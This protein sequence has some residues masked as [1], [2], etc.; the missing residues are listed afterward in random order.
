MY[1]KNIIGQ[2]LLKKHLRQMAD[3]EHIAHALLFLGEEGF[4]SMSLPLAFAQYLNCRERKDGDACGV[5]PSCVKYHSLA[6]PDLH[7]LFPIISRGTKKTCDDYLD[8]WREF[9]SEEKYFDFEDWLQ[10]IEAG[11]SQP[12]IYSA[13]SNILIKK[14]AFKSQEAD[15]RVVLIWM[16]EKMNEVCANKLLKLIEEPPSRTIFLMVSAHADAIL[17]TIL[18]RT[19]Q[20]IVPPIP[21][22]ELKSALIN[23][24]EVEEDEAAVVARIAGA[25]YVT[26]RRLLIDRDMRKANFELFATLMR[27]AWSRNIKGMKQF[28]EHLNKLGREAQKAFLEY[29]QNFIRESYVYNFNM[30]QINYLTRREEEFATNFARFIHARNVEE[31]VEELALAQLH[32]ERNVNSKMIFFDLS[33]RMTASIRKEI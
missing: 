15:W 3:Q 28:A 27:N 13:E 26:A 21:D 29:A 9:L 33:L 11:N 30:H 23:N 7:F 5:C 8:L 17:P 12:Q 25:N 2:E 10:K 16:P 31:L 32:V 14:L 1:F 18:S 20:I 6:H 22:Q 4:G 24:F 19:Q